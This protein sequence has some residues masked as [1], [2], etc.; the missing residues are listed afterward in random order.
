MV[1]G[2]WQ[3]TLQDRQLYTAPQE[4]K[5]RSPLSESNLGHLLYDADA[6]LIE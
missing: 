3:N 5:K 1:Q 2:A 4:K 6:Y